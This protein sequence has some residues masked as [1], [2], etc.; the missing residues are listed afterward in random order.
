[1][2]I[3]KASNSVLSDDNQEPVTTAA[4][5]YGF[6]NYN[7]SGEYFNLQYDDNYQIQQYHQE[8]RNHYAQQNPANQQPVPTSMYSHVEHIT[9]QEVHST[10][11]SSSESCSISGLR[12]AC[13]EI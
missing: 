7:N 10:T 8:I 1:M 5:H 2:S 13:Y 12:T 9:T 3:G 6:S 11:S 4:A